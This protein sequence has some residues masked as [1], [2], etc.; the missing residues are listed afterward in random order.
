VRRIYDE[1]QYGVMFSGH[2]QVDDNYITHRPNGRGDWLIAY[3]VGG[4]GYFA[5]DGLY[6]EC[7]EGDVALLRPGAPHTYGTVKGETWNFVWVHFPERAIEDH[8]LPVEPLH[9]QHLDAGSLR[10]R[11]HEAFG[12]ILADSR[13]R[14]DFWYELSLNSLREILMLLAQQRERRLDPRI[15]EALHYLSVHMRSPLH[16][17]RLARTIGLSPSRL[18]HLFKEQTGLPIVD[19]LNRMRILQAALLLEHTHR[20]AA[21]IAYDVGFHNYNHFINQFRKWLG[22]TPSAYRK[23]RNVPHE[24]S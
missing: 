3:T 23:A 12:R 21:E 2:F 17:E 5:T 4:R 9:V 7:G 1:Q 22:T 15:A 24:E 6:R 8:L 10:T 13:E 11:I 16:I 14:S 19:T 18:S 20:S